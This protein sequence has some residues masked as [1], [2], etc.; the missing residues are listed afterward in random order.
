MCLKKWRARFQERCQLLVWGSNT[1]RKCERISKK[2]G[3]VIYITKLDQTMDN[4][5]LFTKQSANW[6]LKLISF[7]RIPDN[8]A[9]LHDTVARN[10]NNNTNRKRM[11][12]T[13]R[14]GGCGRE[15]RIQNSW[16]SQ[17]EKNQNKD[18]LCGYFHRTNPIY[19]KIQPKC[20][21]TFFLPEE[22]QPET[23]L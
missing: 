5:R 4:A 6:P 7:G 12:M 18:R 19:F 23:K 2:N 14:K 17:A 11:R 8:K 3:I 13:K 1:L 9:R 22:K 10:D 15:R 16:T 21:W 20:Q